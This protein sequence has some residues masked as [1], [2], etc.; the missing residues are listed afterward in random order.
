[1]PSIKTTS[2]L[3]EAEYEAKLA[4]YAKNNQLDIMNHMQIAAKFM[5][6]EDRIKALEV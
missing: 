4:Q 2:T 6:L 1:M 3:P 5:D